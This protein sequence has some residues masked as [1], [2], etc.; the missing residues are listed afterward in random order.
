MKS[1]LNRKFYEQGI[2]QIAERLPGCILKRKMTPDIVLSGRI[3]EVEIYTQAEDPASH[4]YNGKTARNEVMFGDPGHLYVYFTYGM[5]YCC[6]IV[7]GPEGRG[8]AILIRGV[9]PLGGI[10]HMMANRFG[11]ASTD[12]GKYAQLTN[13]PAKL[14]QAYAIDKQ[15]NGEDLCGNRIWVEEGKLFP[16]ETVRRSTRIGIRQGNEM[17]RRYYIQDNPWVSKPGK[18]IK[19]ENE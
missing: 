14:C 12:S 6:N 7:C 11:S 8:D 4:S 10:D 17:F 3:V 2:N 1:I 16:G 13:G 9:E 15:M 19:F 18:G 5:H